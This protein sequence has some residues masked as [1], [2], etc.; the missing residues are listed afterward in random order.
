MITYEQL[1]GADPG[2]WR[3]AGARWR[4]ALGTVGGR[5][6][7]LAPAATRLRSAWSGPAAEAADHRLADLRAELAVAGPALLEI[8][9]VLAEYAARLDLARARLA[10]VVA[11]AER[12]GLLVDR[13]GAVSWDP[14]RSGP[15]AAALRATAEVAAGIRGVLTLATEADLA[16]ARRLT[17]LVSAAGPGRA[18]DARADP[19]APDAPPAAVRRWWD[20]LTG[21]QRWWLIAHRPELVGHLDGVPVVV[22]DQANRLLLAARRSELTARRNGLSARLAA[23]TVPPWAFVELRRLSQELAGLDDLAV[24]LGADAGPRAYLLALDT[25]GDGRAVVAVDDPDHADNVLTYVPGMTSDLA[26]IGG[27][28]GR[29]QRMAERCAEL[30]PGVRT[31]AVLWL[32]YDAPDFVD[33]AASP[34]AAREAGPALHRFQEGLRATHDG[35]PARQTVLG[36]SYGSLVVGATARDHGLAA[37][38]LIFVGSPGVGV[39][40][41]ADLGLPAGQIW[42]S[43]AGN[44]V[45]QYAA[46]S[47]GELLRGVAGALSPVGGGIP[48]LAALGWPSDQLW[49]GHNPVDAGFGG[50]TFPGAPRGHTGYWDPGNPAL[51]GM[52]RIA[53]TGRP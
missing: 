4:G 16:A 22:R 17:E 32:D 46:R 48:A 37:D 15:D 45:I 40:H 53:L 21:A 52:A 12:S 6:V 13:S 43:T 27:E 24:R 36:H 23:G 49:F 18:S 44:D 50:R 39:E 33:S 1:W 19:P 38:S 26:G 35:P 3:S 25:A 30:G 9:T 42:A 20:A 41:A 34:A 2:A 8:D 29:V 14:A 5:E 28:L 51:D 11:T 10:G 47:R 31:A 7:E